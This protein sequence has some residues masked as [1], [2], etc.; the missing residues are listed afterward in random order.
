MRKTTIAMMAAALAATPALA[1]EPHSYSYVEVGW[2]DYTTEVDQD[3]GMPSDDIEGDGYSI[4]ASYRTEGGA[5]F[6]GH[7]SDGEI[8]KFWGLSLSG[9]GID[10]DMRTYGVLVGGTN[11]INERTSFWAGAGYDREEI[12]GRVQGLGSEKLTADVW[13]F[14]GGFRFWTAPMIE[15]NAGLRFVHA[16]SDDLDTSDNDGELSLGLRFQPISWLSV[17]ASYA[18]LLDA[19]SEM[20]KADVRYQF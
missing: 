11:Q 1:Y 18:R 15:L 14:G 19:E 4:A 16:S 10:L 5:L 20:L 6:Q 13:H 2:W 8:D 9:T 17:G 7:Y 12:K 3:L